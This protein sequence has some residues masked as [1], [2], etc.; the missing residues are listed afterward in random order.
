[1]AG[2]KYAIERQQGRGS[3]DKRRKATHFSFR[4]TTS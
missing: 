4:P 1:M 2:T 3:A